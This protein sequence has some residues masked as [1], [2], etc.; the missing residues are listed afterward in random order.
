MELGG[1]NKLAVFRNPPKKYI[2]REVKRFPG[3][4]T[5]QAMTLPRL[6]TLRTEVTA[7]GGDAW[8]VRL[9]VHN[10]GYLPHSVTNRALD[11]KV[12]RGS[13]FATRECSYV[14]IAITPIQMRLAPCSAC[15]AIRRLDA[16]SRFWGRCSNSAAG[17][18]RFTAM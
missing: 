3:W 12:T 18:S 7:L 5:W 10:Q 6:E 8:R 1:W 2:E 11:G 4:L 14:T 15:C 13:A 16:G 17:L 9:A